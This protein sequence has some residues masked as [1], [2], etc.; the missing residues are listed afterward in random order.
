MRA[1]WKSTDPEAS[2]SPTVTATSA[3]DS[4]ATSSR[5]DDEAKATLSVSIVARRWR[6]VTDRMVPT[7]ASARRCATSVGSPRTTSRK[8]PDS[9]SRACHWRRARSRVVMPTSAANTGISGR[10]SPTTSPD[11]GSSQVMAAS[12]TSGS[13]VA[14]TRAGR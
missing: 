1:T 5:T 9:A 2:R 11:S 13:T 4:V 6:C 3:T 8:C 14:G 12:V 7:C 10:V